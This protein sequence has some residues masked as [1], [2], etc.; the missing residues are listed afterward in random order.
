VYK[1]SLVYSL[2]FTDPQFARLLFWYYF[3]F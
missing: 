3:Y 1:L 2:T